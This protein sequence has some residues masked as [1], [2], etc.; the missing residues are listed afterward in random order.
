MVRAVNTK[1]LCMYGTAKD[2]PIPSLREAAKR[3]PKN[4]SAWV[5]LAEAADAKGDHPALIEAL[6]KLLV[7]C[8]AVA[9]Y[10]FQ[11]GE[12]MREQKKLDEARRLFEQVLEI[13]PMHLKARRHLAELS[14]MVTP[15]KAPTET[16]RQDFITV[17]PSPKMTEMPPEVMAAS[18]PIPESVLAELGAKRQGKRVLV[19]DFRSSEKFG[20]E[21]RRT[22]ET[23]LNELK[24]L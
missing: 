5:S 15:V 12:I 7:L 16:R 18:R 8:P 4:E 6:Q 13:S 19:P 23:E 2:N 20:K 3:D 22:P 11:L 10:R 1:N 9:R 14:G 21:T 24:P 17:T